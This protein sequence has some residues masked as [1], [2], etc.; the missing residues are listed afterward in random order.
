MLLY[1]LNEFLIKIKITTALIYSQKNVRISYLKITINYKCYITIKFTLPK[2]LILIK[3]VNQ[4]SAIFVT[5]GIFQ[6]KGLSFDHIYAMDAMI[7]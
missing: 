5:I 6:M 1:T 7:Y 3:Q 4:K 2:E